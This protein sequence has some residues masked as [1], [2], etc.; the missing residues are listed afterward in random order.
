MHTGGSVAQPFMS[1]SAMGEVE[2]SVFIRDVWTQKSGPPYVVRDVCMCGSQ[3]DARL[4]CERIIQDGLRQYLR[5][6]HNILYHAR[7]A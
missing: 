4:A 7:N 2:S 3:G 6:C 1:L 5:F